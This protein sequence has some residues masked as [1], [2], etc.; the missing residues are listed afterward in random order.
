MYVTASLY[1]SGQGNVTMR[2]RADVAGRAVPR[3]AKPSP[4][5]GWERSLG[6]QAVLVIDGQQP[7]AD[8]QFGAK[9]GPCAEVLGKVVHQRLLGFTSLGLH[10][11]QSTVI[12]EGETA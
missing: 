11:D 6:W 3:R 12:P 2:V 8:G 9:L 5:D 7:T 1:G 10:L 4:V